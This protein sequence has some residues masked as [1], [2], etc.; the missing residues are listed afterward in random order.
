[1]LAV[2]AGALFGVSDVAVKYLTH[3]ARSGVLGS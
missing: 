1:M 3:A 2:A